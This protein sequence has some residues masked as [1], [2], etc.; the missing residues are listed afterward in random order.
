MARTWY[1]T[2][3][4]AARTVAAMTLL[5]A[6]LLT[7]R[8]DEG[9]ALHF[10]GKDGLGKGKKIVLVAGDEEYRSE[11]ALPQ[12][13]KILATRHGFDCTVV[14]PIDPKTGEVDPNV[15]NNLPGLEALADAD[16]VILGLRFRNPPEDQMK[17][18]DDYVAAG[19]PIIGLRTSTHAFNTSSDSKYAKYGW[20]SKTDWAGG[21][22]KQILGE[23]WVAHHGKH[24]S[25]STRGVPAPGDAKNH[26]IL[27]GVVD[28]W[29]PSDVYTVTTPL[30]GDSVPLLMGQV[31]VGMKPTDEPVVG[32][33]NDPMMPL[34]WTKTYEGAN[35]RKGRVFTTTMGA[36]Q[37]FESEGLRR[38]V[39]N[40][41]YWC[42]GMEDAVRP[43]ADVS[44]VGAY[45]PTP[46]KF[47]G[48]KKGV[49]PADLAK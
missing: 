6:T 36:S 15:N 17:H 28:V 34:A 37:D 39:V 4:T 35:G 23:T 25:Q 3:E 11:E 12:L 16:L 21:F 44:Y 20:T 22:G 45:A 42:L 7:A 24:G 2:S 33:V 49:K 47:N 10:P 29:G 30:P 14:L 43:D 8:A 31:L 19:K 41:A 18:F 40:A 27:R 9:P 48:A 32:G 1:S 26:P 38:L 13:A 46:F 5:G